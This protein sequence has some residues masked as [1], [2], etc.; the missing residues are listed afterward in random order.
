MVLLPRIDEV[1]E[2]LA[3]V[4]LAVHE[5]LGGLF[6][7][8]LG[9]S[10]LF[11]HSH[12]DAVLAHIASNL[13]LLHLELLVLLLK[14][15]ASRVFDIV[16]FKHL[17]KLLL[18]LEVLVELG[19]AVVLELHVL[20]AHR[21]HLVLLVIESFHGGLVVVVLGEFVGLHLLN[22]LLELL[23]LRLL[24]IQALT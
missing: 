23:K 20:V 3:F 4:D 11:S 7:A 22:A 14:L 21:F 8:V 1:L 6:G 12:D 2:H 9:S 18:L 24:E 13:L 19:F 5:L 16:L 15:Q 10:G 17:V